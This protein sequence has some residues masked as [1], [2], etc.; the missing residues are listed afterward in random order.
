MTRPL[1]SIIIPCYNAGPMIEKCLRSCL[2]QTY[3]PIEIIVVD[4]NS[5]DESMSVV[6]RLKQQHGELIT[7]LSCHQPGA[8]LARNQGFRKAKGDYIQWLDADDELSPDKIQR[9]VEALEKEKNFD[10]AY[11]SWDLCIYDG[12]KIIETWGM[13]AVSY[14]DFFLE[15]LIDNWRPPHCYLLRRSIADRMH[16]WEGWTP[17]E[18]VMQD[19]RYF[20][21]AAVLGAR[22][23][24]VPT[25]RVAYNRWSS[26]QL[27]S[28]T[29]LDARSPVMKRMFQAL[30][31]HHNQ[32]PSIVLTKNHEFLIH[33]SKDLWIAQ[34][35]HTTDLKKNELAVLNV[36]LDPNTYA[37]FDGFISSGNA[38]L[39]EIFASLIV[40]T[41]WRN[42]PSLEQ[43]DAS[44]GLAPSDR[45]PPTPLPYD[46]I[47]ASPVELPLLCDYLLPV[48]RI[49]AE[50][51][52]K[53]CLTPFQSSQVGHPD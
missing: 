15:L 22:F 35:N 1:V 41:L 11:G 4:N 16:A 28:A 46:L 21:F 24:A 10:I 20:T 29:S 6:N 33:M 13:D 36:L 18:R 23:L 43:L 53:G 27:S 44:L 48:L 40:R 45:I 9:Q 52:Q 5:T 50:L 47:K 38:L 30:T 26:Q 37:P 42:N 32:Q 2:Q 39:L 19:R 51:C 34:A 3:R 8:G 49:L 17:V 25:A 14:E 12:Q 7:I 31:T